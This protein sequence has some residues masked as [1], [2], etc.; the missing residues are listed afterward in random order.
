MSPAAPTSPAPDLGSAPNR[1]IGVFDSG[2]GGLTVLKEIVS[3]LPGEN[4]IY[5]GDSGRAPYGSKS[6][7]TIGR[8]S[9]QIVR[10]LQ[11]Q[12]VKIIVI[13]CNTASACAYDL[14]RNTAG[15]PVIEVVAP[16]AAAAARIT[17]NGRIGV[18]GTRSTGRSARPPSIRSRF[19]SRPARSSSAWRKRV[20]GTTASR[21][22]SPKPTCV[23]CDRTKSTP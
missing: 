2:L 6:P 20:G 7:E 19:Y 22:R 15:V 23:S 21:A 8:F 1:P 10:F 18:I 11:R 12:Q 5:F 13:A 9:Q 16:G 4:T 3:L 17:R 14:V